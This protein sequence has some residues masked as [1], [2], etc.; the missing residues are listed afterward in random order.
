MF[1]HVLSTK[2]GYK[3]ECQKNLD[4]L[5]AMQRCKTSHIC[6]WTNMSTEV[7]EQGSYMKLQEVWLRPKLNQGSRTR[8][9]PSLKF[10]PTG[11]GSSKLSI[12]R[13]SKISGWSGKGSSLFGG[14]LPIGLQGTSARHMLHCLPLAFCISAFTILTRAQMLTNDSGS[15]H[16]KRVSKREE[17]R[18]FWGATNS[19]KEL[20]LKTI[21]K[22]IW[23]I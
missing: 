9:M 10:Q 13:N 3:A 18:L 22:N 14:K 8:Q 5:C 21:S 19:S 1:T 16:C 11:P 7:N 20:I 15:K 6:R 2:N 12:E 23:T 4:K 17:Q